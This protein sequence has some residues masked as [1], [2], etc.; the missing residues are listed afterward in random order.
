M[1]NINLNIPIF[2]AEEINSD[3]QV[4]GYLKDK[5]TIME[6]IGICIRPVS[7]KSTT[8]AIHFLDMLANDS[9]RLLPNG[10]KDL[11]IFASLSEDGKGGDLYIEQ[12]NEGYII[13]DK[14]ETDTFI[15]SSEGTIPYYKSYNTKK[16]IGIQK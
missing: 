12:D 1:E 13:E 4:I 11:R 10:K 5:D 15:F 16:I 6:I 3:R 7:I 9:D 14:N 2:R 8:L